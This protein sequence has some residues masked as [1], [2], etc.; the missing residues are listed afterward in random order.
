MAVPLTSRYRGLTPYEAAAPDGSVR[1]TVPARFRPPVPAGTPYF[2]T[3]V[4]G[5]T[6]ESLAH[7]YL[8][9]SEAWWQIAD[10][11]PAVFPTE[12]RPGGTLVIPTG[13]EPGLVTRTRA[14]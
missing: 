6:I 10:A 8:G 1:P 5:E 7:R 13:A 2:H 12:L 14:F 9:S 3:V 11:N 4:A